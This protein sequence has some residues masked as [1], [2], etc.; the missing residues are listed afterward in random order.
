M[1]PR[2]ASI[3]PISR[4]FF[5]S[6]LIVSIAQYANGQGIANRSAALCSEM[7]FQCNR[8]YQTGNFVQAEVNCRNLVSCTKTSVDRN[9]RVHTS[10]L[11][12]LG[13]VYF[14]EKKYTEAV[15]VYQRRLAIVQR[16][17]GIQTVEGAIAITDLANAYSGTRQFDKAEPLY[18]QAIRVVETL[19]SRSSDPSYKKAIGK[20][21]YRLRLTY[22]ALLRVTGRNGE[23]DRLQKQ[24]D[25]EAPRP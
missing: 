18:Q 6:F 23:A 22:V 20:G 9:F 19:I 12:M 4:V 8:N 1:I 14:A 25:I 17:I 7:T 11:D 16:N 21:L 24:A 3:L 15:P 2:S 5:S 10:A 13:K